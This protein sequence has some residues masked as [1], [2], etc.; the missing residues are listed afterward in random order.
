LL[1]DIFLKADFHTHPLGDKYYP[2]HFK[3]LTANDKENIFQFLSELSRRGIDILACTDHNTVLPGLWA[4]EIASKEGLPLIVIPGIELNV[5]GATQQMHL[6]GLNINR[7]LPTSRLSIQE[8]AEEIRKQGGV[9]ILAHPV[10]YPQEISHNPDI[11]HSLD[12]IETHNASEGTFLTNRLLD[13][14]SRYQGRFILQTTGSDLHW[15]QT[16]HP[17]PGNSVKHPFFKVPASWLIEKRL[18]TREELTFLLNKIEVQ[19]RGQA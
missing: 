8:A 19:S 14:Y 4:R 2:N 17:R 1:E 15:E 10:K 18:L 9:A 12:G 16:G 6:L 7:D 3:E 11:F 13:E 5:R